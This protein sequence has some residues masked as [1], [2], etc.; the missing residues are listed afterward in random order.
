MINLERYI[1]HMRL[2]CRVQRG[3]ITAP[4]VNIKHRELCSSDYIGQELILKRSWHIQ[5]N[6][7][8]KQRKIWVTV[9]LINIVTD[10][11]CTTVTNIII[12]TDPWCI[13]VTTIN[14]VT[15][16]WGITVTNINIVMGGWCTTVFFLCI[17]Y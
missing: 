8:W 16:R 17:S 1:N 11:W 4:D 13:T 2:A 15:D 6:I 10:G 12:V 14:I 5:F 3:I 9:T 7:Y